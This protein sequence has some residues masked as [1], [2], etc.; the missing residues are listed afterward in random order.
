[1]EGWMDGWMEDEWMDGWGT[2]LPRQ[3][4]SQTQFGISYKAQ[5]STKPVSSVCGAEAQ[6]REGGLGRTQAHEDGW[7]P[8]RACLSL[9][10]DI[11]STLVVAVPTSPLWGCLVAE[12]RRMRVGAL[13]IQRRSCAHLQRMIWSDGA[14]SDWHG[15]QKFREMSATEDSGQKSHWL[16]GWNEAIFRRAKFISHCPLK[17]N[18]QR[19]ICRETGS[20]CVVQMLAK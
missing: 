3:E 14:A 13:P 16:G 18:F 6:E 15:L 17:W 8:D 5:T 1:M 11:S 10:R 20:R 19:N 4:L 7:P 12:C 2:R 9:G